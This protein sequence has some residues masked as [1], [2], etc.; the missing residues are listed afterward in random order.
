M[1]IN[2]LLNGMILQVGALLGWY[3]YDLILKGD[4][5]LHF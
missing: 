1:V 5:V 4:L 2:N 3:V